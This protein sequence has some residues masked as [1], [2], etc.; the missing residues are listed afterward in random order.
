MLAYRDWRKLAVS[1]TAE[2]AHDGQS[3]LYNQRKEAS[4]GLVDDDDAPS[5]NL[6][7]VISE[8]NEKVRL[9]VQSSR[10]TEARVTLTNVLSSILRSYNA[11]SE[12]AGSICD[13]VSSTGA[14]II[15]P[16][17]SE[18]LK[19]V[20]VEDKYFNDKE[21]F[22]EHIASKV[23]WLIRELSVQAE[24][25]HMFEEKAHRLFELL[26]AKE[27]ARMAT[28]KRVKELQAAM[29]TRAKE[30]RAAESQRDATAKGLETTIRGLR[31]KVNMLLV[32]SVAQK[33]RVPLPQ[34]I[35]SDAPPVA[36]KPALL[37]LVARQREVSKLTDNEANNSSASEVPQL[38]ARI[39]RLQAALDEA[40]ARE[41]AQKK[42]KEKEGETM[43]A[44]IEHLQAE[45]ERRQ[46]LEKQW[47]QLLSGSDASGSDKHR[48]EQTAKA[49]SQK[50]MEIH[51]LQQELDA[52]KQASVVA[53]ANY[54][55]QLTVVEEF[56]QKRDD[57]AKA[58]FEK[59]EALAG[60][61]RGRREDLEKVLIDEKSEHERTRRRL[62]AIQNTLIVGPSSQ[63]LLEMVKKQNNTAIPEVRKWMKG[64]VAWIQSSCDAGIDPK[65][66]SPPSQRSRRA[67]SMQLP[68][69]SH[70]ESLGAGENCADDDDRQTC[71]TS[72][73]Q[74]LLSSATATDN[75]KRRTSVMLPK[76]GSRQ[77]TRKQE[78]RRSSTSQKLLETATV[79]PTV[80]SVS[81]QT[82]QYP[83]L[84]QPAQPWEG[85]H[86]IS[87]LSQLLS[88]KQVELTELQAT[89]S[90]TQK[91]LDEYPLISDVVSYK[92][93]FFA[94]CE[95]CI[96]L[97]NTVFDLLQ[98]LRSAPEEDNHQ[99]LP[100]TMPR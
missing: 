51:L 62:R 80:A 16:T 82:N 55:K 59:M 91:Q 88:Q 86:E 100:N 23:S 39:E 96:L 35:P 31:E 21:A 26:E 50:S 9:D 71:E 14:S 75:S 67:Q 11:N 1:L 87:T 22:N 70:R 34:S 90:S 19:L 18:A 6:Q 53:R 74:P 12:L 32:R 85:I 27:N 24:R 78:H 43:R 77:G 4:T 17:V 49:V 10:K 57:E 13:R 97:E 92:D 5:S 60:D 58:L 46:V 81:V 33:K 56:S 73:A 36:A 7:Q 2:D 37:A 72:A 64:L 25:G 38:K 95:Q 79:F 68:E 30:Y 28:L 66:R 3:R 69:L 20:E 44:G 40:K 89:L 48:F 47:E 29:A 54:E 61:E 63:E 76:S 93:A 83:S 8:L 52:A 65:M 15:F 45:I 84:A 42:R 41:A 99:Q 94:K 98:K